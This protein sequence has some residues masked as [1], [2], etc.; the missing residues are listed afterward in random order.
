MKAKQ[1]FSLVLCMAAFT[2]CG[3]GEKVNDFIDADTNIGM[4]APAVGDITSVTNAETVPTTTTEATTT[5]ALEDIIARTTDD[6]IAGMT[7]EEKIGQLILAR[8]PSDPVTE[9]ET[10]QLG[11]YTFYA[12]DFEKQSPDGFRRLTDDITKKAS[13]HPFYAVDE[14]GGSIVRVSKFTQFRDE[15]FPSPQNTFDRGGT[16]LLEIDGREK[17]ELLRSIGL[18]FNLA[19][20]A[21]ISINETSYIY[22]RTIGEGADETSEAVRTI[23]HTANEN[24]LAS[25]LKH[26]P[27]YGEN[28][29]THKGMAHDPREMYEFYNRDFKVFTAGIEADTDKIPAVMVGHTVYDGIDPSAPASLS[30]QVHDILRKKLGFSGVAVTDDLGME[31][32]SQYVTGDSVYVQALLAGNDLLCV[33]DYKTAYDDLLAA[34]ENGTITDEELELHL[35]RIILMKIQYGIIEI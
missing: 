25:C 11:G 16:E 31:A 8:A 22:P 9:M 20:V 32:I 2:A 7:T 30:P 28:T 27:G 6:I 1:L 3:I 21:D 26:F 4:N 10:Y 35:H 13:V 19:P 24:G 12:N 23:V 14:E 34:Y 17:A 15:P 5:E 33:T 29:D 18:N